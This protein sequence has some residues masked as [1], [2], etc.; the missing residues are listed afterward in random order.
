MR[1]VRKSDIN[2]INAGFIQTLANKYKITDLPEQDRLTYLSKQLKDKQKLRSAE[3]TKFIII[4]LIVFF[5]LMCLFI[6]AIIYLMKPIPPPPPP[7]DFTPEMV[8]I[9]K[10]TYRIGISQRTMDLLVSDNYASSISFSNEM[11]HK[12][13][14]V[15]D[16]YIS[17][18]EI[19]VGQ[20][21]AYLKDTKQDTLILEKTFS[22]NNQPINNVT[23]NDAIGYC[24]WLSNKAGTVV[25]LPYE[26]EWEIAAKGHTDNLYAWGN[27]MPDKNK[28]NFQYSFIGS[29]VANDKSPTN[30]SVFH[31]FNMSGNVAEWCNDFYHADHYYLLKDTIIMQ[32]PENPNRVI[33]G[34]GF[35]D[36]TF[37]LRCTA[38]FF[39][40]ANTKSNNIGFRIVSLNNLTK[41]KED[42]K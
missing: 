3:L 2:E 11:P 8:L 31:V 14:N 25:R 26:I 35:Q 20:F 30:E 10:G 32:L 28:C 23:W 4:C 21:N 22:S 29:T 36:I 41:I 9:P 42:Q 12:D 34:G 15:T 13:I 40:P 27:N 39:A 24:R 7:P 18:Y 38:R 17:K 33:R 16:F 1:E 19:T 5:W 6:L 37:Y